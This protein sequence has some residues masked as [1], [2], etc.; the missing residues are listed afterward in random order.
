M[1]RMSLTS[2]KTCCRKLGLA[3]WPYTRGGTDRRAASSESEASGREEGSASVLPSLPGYNTGKG[4]GEGEG[5]EPLERS[6]IAWY[7]QEDE[8]EDE[9]EENEDEDEDE[10]QEEE[11]GEVKESDQC[12]HDRGVYGYRGG[13]S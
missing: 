8:E 7:M 13:W 6:W 11:Q 10:Q 5:W 9:E 1:T 2:L 4:E 3:R 12:L